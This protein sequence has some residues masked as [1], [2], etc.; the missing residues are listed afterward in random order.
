MPS[1]ALFAIYNG[2]G[3]VFRFTIVGNTAVGI[4]ISTTFTTSFNDATMCPEALV[5]P[6]AD[7]QAVKAV[8]PIPAVP[9]DQILYT[10]LVSNSGPDTADN[11]T[12]TDAVP[13]EVLAPE[14]SL[15]QGATFLPWAGSLNLGT[16]PSGKFQPVL[17][18]GTLS[19]SGLRH[20]F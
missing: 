7:A 10:V 19:P 14:Y 17:I 12:L 4:Q 13:P 16:F 20:H 15:D 6:I 8:E 2:D 11:M 3:S 1:G 5:G 18:R 9:G